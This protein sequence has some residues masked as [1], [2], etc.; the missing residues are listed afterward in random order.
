ML[1]ATWG[2]TQ[3]AGFALLM[4]P[5]ATHGSEDFLPPSSCS[6]SSL[7]APCVLGPLR[8]CRLAQPGSPCSS[9]LA[10]PSL[11]LLT[12][13][14]LLYCHQ[15]IN[16]ATCF[17]LVLSLWVEPNKKHSHTQVF[18]LNTCA[19]FSA[20]CHHP[21]AQRVQKRARAC[22]PSHPPCWSLRRHRG[23]SLPFC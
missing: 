13:G 22:P 10:L 9:H 23:E 5:M 3:G 6:A 7:P 16:M 15:V 20:S 21:S 1:L 11:P 17:L 8:L 18:Q 14:Q 12:I 19:Y 4:V 2:R